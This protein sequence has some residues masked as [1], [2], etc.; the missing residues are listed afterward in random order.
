MKKDSKTLCK[1]C[2]AKQN[3]EW[4][5][6]T[7]VGGSKRKRHAPSSH[8]TEAGVKTWQCH[9]CDEYKPEDK[10]ATGNARKTQCR[11][12]NKNRASSVNAELRI[13][14][15]S[16]AASTKTRNEKIEERNKKWHR[17]EPLLKCTITLD[18]LIALYE[19]Q[20]TRCFY[21][22]AAFQ[23]HSLLAKGE[24]FNK[25]RQMSLE[26]LDPRRGYESDNV[27][28]ICVGFQSIDKTRDSKHSNGG[29]GG[30][31]RAK[32]A[33]LF[34]VRYE[35]TGP[36][37]CSNCDCV[38]C[39]VVDRA[40]SWLC[41]TICLLAGVQGHVRTSSYCVIDIRNIAGDN[42]SSHESVRPLGHL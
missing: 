25:L 30:W 38:L 7:K 24:V 35:R 36:L 14:L 22:N 3:A 10:M 21:S 28:L 12:C 20:R 13:L 33:Y 17:N 9:W 18:V 41:P 34:Q 40:S 5:K 1:P 26:R 39:A 31:S 2:S 32:V 37:H 16:A 23:H 27:R 19:R 6:N 29:S 4:R 42:S 15:S 11:D 8:K